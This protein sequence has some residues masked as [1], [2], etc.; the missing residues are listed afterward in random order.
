MDVTPF[1]PVLSSCPTNVLVLFCLL[2]HTSLDSDQINLFLSFS[3]PS[4]AI[5][6]PPRKSKNDKQPTY[7]PSHATPSPDTN[8]HPVRL[9]RDLP[10]GN[11]CFRPHMATVEYQRGE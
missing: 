7:H 3:H 11:C 9:R 4:K 2:I 5:Q 8:G 10:R 6:Q 1:L